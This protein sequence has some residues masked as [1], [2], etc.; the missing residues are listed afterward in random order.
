MAGVESTLNVG[1]NYQDSKV[2][3]ANMGPNWV[4]SA[5]DGPHVG[6]MNF[7]IRVFSYSGDSG[8]SYP[9]YIYQPLNSSPPGKNGRHFVVDIFKRIFLNRNV[10]VSRK[11]VPLGPI[12]H[13]SAL[14]QVMARCQTGD[15]PLPEPMLTQFTDAYMRH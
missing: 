15:K 12:D 6:P 10:R 5:P 4:L 14:V 8:G 3:G 1:F 7:A 2:H 11:F 13:K 9:I